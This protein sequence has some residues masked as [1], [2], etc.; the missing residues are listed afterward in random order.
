MPRRR[1]HIAKHGCFAAEDGTENG[2]D[3]R[4]DRN[5]DVAAILFRRWRSQLLHE[6]LKQHGGQDER[7]EPEVDV[8]GLLDF[9]SRLFGAGCEHTATVSTKVVR[10][11]VLLRVQELVGGATGNDD[12]AR[13]EHAV[14]LAQGA[15]VIFDVLKGIE[16]GDAVEAFIS[17]RC[18][19][20]MAGQ[21]SG[22]ASVGTVLDALKRDIGPHGLAVLL[23]GFK[24]AT[25]P[26]S[27]VHEHPV[28][29]RVAAHEAIEQR[30]EDGSTPAEP[31]MAVLEF[32][33]LLV[34]GVFH[35]AERSGWQGVSWR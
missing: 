30:N 18:E 1:T 33:E 21:Q 34:D 23:K 12:A 8:T 9:E 3:H 35:G 28:A 17:K 15:D 31:P 16:C 6:F 14:E 27:D 11:L 19:R 2:V 29:L 5:A 24:H 25:D 22:E 10:V 32:Q 20:A 26:T 13:L 7:K 4:I